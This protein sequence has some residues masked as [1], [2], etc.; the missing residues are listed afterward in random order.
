MLVVFILVY[1]FIFLIIIIR[2]CKMERHDSE[3]CSREI[4]WHTS[5]NQF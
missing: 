5:F 3:K 1:I 4:Q 2:I